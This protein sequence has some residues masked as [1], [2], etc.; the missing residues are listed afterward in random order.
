MTLQYLTAVKCNGKEPSSVP[1]KAND[2]TVWLP[3]SLHKE[4]YSCKFCLHHVLCGIANPRVSYNSC[5]YEFTKYIYSSSSSVL[6]LPVIY[7][8]IYFLNQAS[9]KQAW[10]NLF[11]SF[12]IAYLCMSP[13]GLQKMVGDV[14]E[15]LHIAVSR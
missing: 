4:I 8:F 1:G 2:L 14:G 10:L 9:A 11:S 15:I 13:L 5:C 12:S 3:T 6:P 7:L